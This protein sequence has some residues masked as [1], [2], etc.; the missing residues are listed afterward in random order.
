MTAAVVPVPA[1][2]QT[3]PTVCPFLAD[4]IRLGLIASESHPAGNVTGVLFR[5]PGLAG[6]QLAFGLQLIPWGDED[7]AVGQCREPGCDR[8][9][10]SGKYGTAARCHFGPC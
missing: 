3:I 1:R 5:V 9:A 2:T 7:R 4:P 6:K 10:R 8:S